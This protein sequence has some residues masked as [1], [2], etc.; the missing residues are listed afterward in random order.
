MTYAAYRGNIPAL[1]LIISS[2]G[3]SKDRLVRTADREGRNI[4]HAAA[5]GGNGSLFLNIKD[6]YPVLISKKDVL[7]RTPEEI[8]HS[9]VK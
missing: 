4:L 5:E 3:K 2:L 1:M 6:R 7:G 9:K 8:L